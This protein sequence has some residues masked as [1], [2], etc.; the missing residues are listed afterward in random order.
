[1]KGLIQL[2]V[3]IVLLSITTLYANANKHEYKYKINS[4][5]D[6]LMNNLSVSSIIENKIA[7]VEQQKALEELE[8][9]REVER[10]RERVKNLVSR[11]TSRSVPRTNT[12]MKTYMDYR[13]ITNKSSEQYKM[14][15]REDVY[16][17]EEGFRM[18]G[19][20]FIVAV[21][22]YYAKEVGVELA[23]E[24]SSGTVFE[25]VV[26]DIKDDKHTDSTNRQH[27]IDNSV[28]EFIVDVKGMDK[29]SKKMGDCSY[30]EKAG[31]K[32]DIVSIIVVED[33]DK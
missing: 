13:A 15:Q 26:G 11:G 23:I 24:L 14:Q 3:A 9:F 30:A 8:E 10:E 31:L 19:D 7:K 20:K 4:D 5:K 32:G 29:L 25:A 22:T 28:I 33:N 2:V 27:K 16:T 18:I 21:G 6:K 12:S 17:D 1:M